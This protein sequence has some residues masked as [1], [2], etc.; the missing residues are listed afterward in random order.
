[1]WTG[2]ER[3][4]G[5]WRAAGPGTVEALGGELMAVRRSAALGDSPEDARDAFE[6]SLALRG[7]LVVPAERLPVR[8][9][10]EPGTPP[11]S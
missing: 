10:R 2:L 6:L 11:V 5:E 8:R 7:E 1:G 9:L 4:G 3:H